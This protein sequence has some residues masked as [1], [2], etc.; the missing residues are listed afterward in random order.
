[1]FKDLD[2]NLLCQVLSLAF[3][4]YITKRYIIDPVFIK[5]YQCPECIFMALPEP[6]YQVL[7]VQTV[8]GLKFRR[9]DKLIPALIQKNFNGEI[10]EFVRFSE[11]VSFTFANWPFQ[12]A[13]LLIKRSR[14]LILRGPPVISRNA[15]PLICRLNGQEAASCHPDDHQ[16]HQT[17]KKISFGIT[18]FTQIR[19]YPRK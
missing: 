7:F 8:A 14:S 13:E 16:P 15:D 2:E 10:V 6:S 9:Q 19:L 17:L 11:K 18:T 4:L 1:M 12:N 5:L 3:I